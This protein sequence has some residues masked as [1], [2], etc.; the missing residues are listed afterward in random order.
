MTTIL[1]GRKAPLF[2]LA[3]S[4]GQSVSLAEAL[5]RG[6]V[7]AAFFKISCPVCQFALPF[8][9]RL[10]K[11]YGN[12]KVSF[13][14]V[15]QDSARDTRDFCKEYGISFPALVDAKGY[16]ISNDYGLTNV[17]TVFL[18]APD[19]KVRVSSVGFS[20]ADLEKISS[21][22]GAHLHK[23]IAEVFRADEIIPDY[24]PG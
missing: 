3:S 2:T 13:L 9:E 17:P 14:G 7:V 20:R 11:A 1:A 15:S 21:E 8:L 19:G 12:E 4:N 23:P 10:W 16:P 6:P 18:I 22:L 24:K 5:K